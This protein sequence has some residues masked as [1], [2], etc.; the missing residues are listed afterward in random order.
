MSLLERAAKSP[1]TLDNTKLS[2]FKD[3]LHQGDGPQLVCESGDAAERYM[4]VL[5][6]GNGYSLSLEGMGAIESGEMR[7]SV[8]RYSILREWTSERIGEAEA[9][10]DP[11]GKLL[12]FAFEIKASEIISLSMIARSLPEKA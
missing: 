4:A 1:L 2:A 10:R 5:S 9:Q 11:E 6:G 3:K 12:V 7:R 8:E